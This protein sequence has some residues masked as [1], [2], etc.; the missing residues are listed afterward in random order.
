[1]FPDPDALLDRPWAALDVEATG[2]DPAHDAIIEVGAVRFRGQ[3]VLA[4]LSSLV[5]PYRPLPPEVE[6]LTGITPQDLAHAPPFALVAERLLAFIGDAPVVVGHNI[7]VDL[8][9]LER[10]GLRLPALPVDTQEMA[11]VLIP[12]GRYRLE[13]LAAF[14]GI[15]VGRLHR[16]G[17]DARAAALLFA[18]LWERVLALDPSLVGEWRRLATLGGRPLGRLLAVAEALQARQGL[19]PQHGPGG[20]EEGEGL[21]RRLAVPAPPPP[22]TP[23][24]PATE[25]TVRALLGEGGLCASLLPGWER[26][27]QQEEMAYTVLRALREG[28]PLL[29]EAGTGV[30]KTLAYLIPA[31]LVALEQGEPVVVSTA[32]VSLQ[33]QLVQKDL[34]LVSQALARAGSPPLRWALLKGRS[35]YLC[36]RRFAYWRSSPSLSPEM[37]HLL[38]RVALWLGQTATGDRSELALSSRSLPLWNDLSAQ[39]AVACPDGRGPCFLEAARERADGAHILV[40]NHALLLRSAALG[41]SLLPPYRLLIVDEAHHL[42]EEATRQFSVRAEQEGVERLLQRLGGA[43]GLGERAR[44]ASRVFPRRQHEGEAAAQALGQAVAAAQEACATLWRAAEAFVSREGGGEQEVALTPERRRGRLWR[45]AEEAGGRARET[46]REVARWLEA[47]AFSL[48]GTGPTDGQPLLQGVRAEALARAQEVGEVVTA[49]EA[50]F[51]V[52][53]P[54]TVAWVE[55]G[56]EGMA[57]VLAPLRVDTLLRERLFRGLKG[58]VLTS[59]TL[60]VAGDMAAAAAQVGL[61][62]AA[63]LVVDSPFDY[64]RQAAV[65]VPLDMPEPEEG[66]YAPL[67]PRLLG[68]LAVAA[69]GH[70]LALFTSHSALRGAAQALHPLLAPYGIRVLAQGLDGPPQRVAEEFALDPRAI[71]LATASLWEGLDLPPGGLRVLVLTRLPFPVPTSPL[72]AAKARLCADPFRELALP[73]AVL[74]FRQGFGRL[75]RR[76]TDR[77]VVVV[78]DRRLLSRPYGALFLRSLPPC[79]VERLPVARLAPWV[80]GWLGQ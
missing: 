64:R 53:S 9:F 32:T 66:G 76:R 29:V 17:E 68:D 56:E 26:R 72:F 61:S 49:L 62:S 5:Q 45:A 40:V 78:L 22:R 41:G 59:A 15:P 39:G 52:A 23:P 4:S 31:A 60:A 70:T 38:A 79:R 50:F 28:R 46:L 80:K 20:V 6:R 10:A 18:R 37:A 42:A 57:F 54:D 65:V 3:E 21:A 71:L 27:P 34:P 2:P 7:A 73:Q 36:L 74:R 12:R 55:R 69:G 13:D 1:V 48:E 11:E 16:A 14:Y 25:A 44:L 33:E 77:G 47:V 19:R 8:A 51:G 24:L 75:I 43:G 63:H 58:G 35:H 67:L 30:G